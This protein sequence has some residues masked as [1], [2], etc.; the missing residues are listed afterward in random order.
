MKRS[1]AMQEKARALFK[2]SK[3]ACHI[4]GRAISYDAHYLEPDAF[5]VDH[6]VPLYRGGA[7]ALSNLMAAH[8]QRSCNSKKRARTHAP[9]IRRSGA[10][11]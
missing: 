11:D 9:I 10:F 3:P 4:C 5:V 2:R 7:D 8:R 6:V 1:S